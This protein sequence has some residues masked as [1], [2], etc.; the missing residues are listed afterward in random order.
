MY[1]IVRDGGIKR[2]DIYP[3][4]YSESEPGIDILVRGHRTTSY[5]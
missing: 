1:I 3:S 4:R 5:I 2:V